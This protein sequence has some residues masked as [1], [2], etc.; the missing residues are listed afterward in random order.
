MLYSLYIL[1]VYNVSGNIAQNIVRHFNL[2][3]GMYVTASMDEWIVN[4][5]ENNGWDRERLVTGCH[6]YKYFI[7]I[8]VFFS[9]EFM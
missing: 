3:L 8:T 7:V 2:G 5:K 6:R 4:M 1:A 9:L